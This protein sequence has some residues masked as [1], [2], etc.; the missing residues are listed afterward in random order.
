[1]KLFSENKRA[2]RKKVVNILPLECYVSKLSDRIVAPWKSDA[3]KIG[4]FTLE[5]SPLGQ[6]SVGQLS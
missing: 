5:D 4:I 6:V 1:V 2:N 3:L